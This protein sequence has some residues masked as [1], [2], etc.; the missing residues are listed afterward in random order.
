MAHEEPI[1]QSAHAEE[2]S[3]AEPGTRF[4]PRVGPP[5]AELVDAAASVE[6]EPKQSGQAAAANTL[7]AQEEAAV[8][9]V[10]APHEGIHSWRQFML[11]M[12]TIVLGLL[13]AISLEQS[14]EALHRAHER[15]ELL[16]SLRRDTDQAIAN[17]QS[18]EQANVPP[19]HW[20]TVRQQ[21]IGDALSA[22]SRITDRLPVAPNVTS[23]LPTDPAWDAAKSSGL[24]SLLTQ[25]EV[26]VYSFADVLLTQGFQDFNLGLAASGKRSR[27]EF[28]FADPKNPGMLDLSNA[29]PAD[30]NQY[31]DLLLDERLAWNQYRVICEYIRGAE[32]AIREGERDP[33]KVRAAM[34]QFHQRLAR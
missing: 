33:A 27:F 29:T 6:A 15:T 26:E 23:N 13:I 21:F 9:D 24:L 22:R 11:H 16:E 25:D 14:V 17:A 30:L 5:V 3:V 7:Q 18:S 31:R 34:Y 19:L 28:K 2:V 32:T 12:C 4:A 10:H 1:S 8:L 20:L